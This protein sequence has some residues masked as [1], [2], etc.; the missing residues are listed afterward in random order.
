[1]KIRKTKMLEAVIPTA[2]MADIAFL[3]IVFFMISTVLSEWTK[4][5]FNCPPVIRKPDPKKRIIKES[6]FIII[7]KD[8]SIKASDGQED[9]PVGK[10]GRHFRP[11][12]H[13]DAKKSQSARGY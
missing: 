5:M 6:A 9:S 12:L 11:R 2:S 3:L 1:M 13:V 7:K 10:P 8:G 4:Q